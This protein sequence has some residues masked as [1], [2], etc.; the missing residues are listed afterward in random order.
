LVGAHILSFLRV[1]RCKRKEV[2]SPDAKKKQ[3]LSENYY[4]ILETLELLE[5]ADQ[6]QADTE[7]GNEVTGAGD[8]HKTSNS[9]LKAVSGSSTPVNEPKIN[10]VNSSSVLMDE[11]FEHQT[12]RAVS[13]MS[14]NS[15]LLESDELKFDTEDIER[16]V[17][18]AAAGSARS[19]FASHNSR[20]SALSIRDCSTI[21]HDDASSLFEARRDLSGK[22][23]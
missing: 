19:A 20:T 6:Q 16:L 5:V 4:S 18:S 11:L 17:N 12:S 3:Q 7:A 10:M 15:H 21:P 8:K 23:G 1:S 22:T 9:S 2:Q 13:G 14:A